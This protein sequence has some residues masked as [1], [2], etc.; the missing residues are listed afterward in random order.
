MPE[1][2]GATQPQRP[3][4]PSQAPLEGVR[5]VIAVSSCKG[6]VGKSTVAVNLALALAAKGLQV[7]LADIDIYGP[8]APT[9]LGI[10]ERPG[11]GDD[12]RIPPLQAHGISVMSMGFFLDDN[13]PVSWRGPMAMSATRQFL[14]GVA[15]GDLDVLVVDLPPGTGD[16]V[17]TLC[18][19]I[20]LDGAVVVTT[21]QDLALADVK[22]G[23][24]MFAKVNTPVLGVI[25]NMS[26]YVCAKCGTRDELFGARSGR[27]LS[28]ELGL[29]LLGE[30]PID[31]SVCESGDAGVPIVARDPEHAVSRVFVDIADRVLATA[32][33]A[34][35]RKLAPE[36]VEVAQEKES[37]TLRIRWS[38]GVT[39]RYALSGLRGWCP[40]AGCQGHGGE[41]RFV[42][43]GAPRLEGVEGV[44]RYALRLIWSDGHE[45]GMY[46]FSYLR[47]L[48][49]YAEC[50]PAP[51]A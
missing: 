38:D 11:P 2:P 43:S 10:S 23:I 45:T 51:H 28:S 41:R 8:S 9:M 49:D 20:P 48:A 33:E 39:T 6:G 17:L 3:G 16:I 5:R 50:R 22:R 40:C 30:I 19:E 24:A 47:E 7:G 25:E 46:P 44:G 42:P 34:A 36:P 27:Q 12:E 37:K 13:T 31:A 29:G 32:E 21:P 26:A 14:R 1:E 15:W 35:Q 18:Q 4:A